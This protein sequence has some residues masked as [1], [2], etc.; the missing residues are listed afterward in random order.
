MRRSRCSSTITIGETVP[1]R[2]SCPGIESPHPSESA[3]QPAD[4]Y[5][6]QDTPQPTTPR[7]QPRL[8]CRIEPY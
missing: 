2:A 4:I 7:P 6:S 3:L 1:A 8:H 5:H